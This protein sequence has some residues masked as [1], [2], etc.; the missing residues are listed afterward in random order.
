MRCGDVCF[1]KVIHDIIEV[2]VQNA[3]LTEPV[4]PYTLVKPLAANQTSTYFHTLYKPND[5]CKASLSLT[6]KI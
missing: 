2:A 3:H 4:R 1:V 5:M 6:R